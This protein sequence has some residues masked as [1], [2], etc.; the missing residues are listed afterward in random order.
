[1]SINKELNEAVD[2]AMQVAINR[3]KFKSVSEFALQQ[4]MFEKVD[5]VSVELAK[6]LEGT[7]KAFSEFM[8][9]MNGS[10]K[11]AAN[12][13]ADIFLGDVESKED[14]LGRFLEIKKA[15]IEVLNGIRELEG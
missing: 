8:Q 2:I 11:Y 6:K 4:N 14:I 9:K 12:G 15:V 5:R 13:E 7:Q 10:L 3:D 1:Y